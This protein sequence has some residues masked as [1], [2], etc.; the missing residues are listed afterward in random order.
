MLYWYQ[1]H[2]RIIASEYQ[3]KLYMVLDAIRLGRTDSA[4]VRIATKV[5]KTRRGM[6]MNFAGD[7]I[8]KLD[9]LIPR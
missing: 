2:G 9:E 7:V 1:S 5:G 4:L 8:P 6:A 3:A